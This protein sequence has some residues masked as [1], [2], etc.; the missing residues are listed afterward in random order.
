M[1]VSSHAAHQKRIA[2][3]EFAGAIFTNITQDHLDY[4]GTFQNYLLAKQAFFNMLPSSA[5]AVTNRDD[6]NGKWM[7]QNTKATRKT[8]SLRSMA[9][10]RARV[11]EKTF[12][13]MLIDFEGHETYCRLTGKFNAYNLLAIF[14]AACEMGL[15]PESVLPALS[16]LAP[17]RGRFELMHFA[18]GVIGLVDYAHTP[19]ALKNVLETVWEVH[20]TQG[21]VI[22][23]IGCGGDRDAEKRPE[24]GKI[25]VQFSDTVIFTSDNPRTEDPDAII[26][27]MM[28]GVPL[29]KQNKV[30]Q[31]ADRR[32]AIKIGARLANRGDVMLLAGKGHETYQEINGERRYFNDR[33]ELFRA[34]EQVSE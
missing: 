8:Y 1:E 30:L 2:G 33:E 12:E 15:E 26:A 25:A 7:L 20:E 14:A 32:E 21:Q 22:T 27:E 6:R 11:M 3:I 13:G 4:H 23:I 31:V 16:D 10:Y 9:D 28:Q 24:M 34:V 19:D 18:N 29:T 17:A 5:F